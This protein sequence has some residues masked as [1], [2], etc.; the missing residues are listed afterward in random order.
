MYLRGA[1]PSLLVSKLFN[2]T[3]YLLFLGDFLDQGV[4]SPST[5]EEDDP[6]KDRKNNK[7]RGIFPKVATNVMRAWLFQHLTVKEMS[8]S[9]PKS[10]ANVLL[11]FLKIFYMPVSQTHR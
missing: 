5:G 8:L 1:T 7:K 10:V 11:R 9:V 4:A 6:D 3:V 2:L